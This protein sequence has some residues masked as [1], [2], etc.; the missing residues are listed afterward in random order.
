MLLRRLLPAVALAVLLPACTSIRIGTDDPEGRGIRVD[1][2]VDGYANF[3]GLERYDGEILYAGIFGS[4]QGDDL[5]TL[6]IWPLG[7]VGV[8]LAGARVRFL[9]L[10]LG[11][12]TLGYDP[13]P[14]RT[15][16]VEIVEIDDITEDDPDLEVDNDDD[17]QW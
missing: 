17:P 13:H 12:G 2:L 10:E 1:G 3:D 7:G 4:A 11:L 6:D 14:F 9:P 5:A 15:P 16:P 8:G